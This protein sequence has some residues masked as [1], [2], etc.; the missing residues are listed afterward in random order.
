MHSRYGNLSRCP[1]R[2]CC[3]E[4]EM[5]VKPGKKTSTMETGEGI[6]P[7]SLNMFI[8]DGQVGLQAE[9]MLLWDQRAINIRQAFVLSENQG[10]SFCSQNTNPVVKEVLQSL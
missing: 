5:L 10:R 9:G 4:A 7:A 8:V 6:V 3:M 2:S 1:A